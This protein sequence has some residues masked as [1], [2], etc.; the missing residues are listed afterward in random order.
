MSNIVLT[1]SPWRDV[2]EIVVKTKEKRS[3]SIMIHKEPAGGYETNV[4]ISDPVSPQPK[5][6]DYLLDSTMPSSTA[7]QHF[8]DSLKL[9]TGY[10]KQFAP[11]DQMVS[12]HNPCSAPF[13]SE[14]D[15]NAVLT[16]MGF[17]ITVTVN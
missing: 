16:A 9:I 4:L 6:W 10:L 17:N 3:C 13:V 1:V 8:E 2:H 5:T 15:Q 11:T 14:P 7:K 12:F